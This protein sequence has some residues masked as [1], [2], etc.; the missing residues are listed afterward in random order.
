GTR[1]KPFFYNS[2]YTYAYGKIIGK[3]T[4]SASQRPSDGMV[5]RPR[6]STPTTRQRRHSSNNVRFPTWIHRARALSDVWT[7]PHAESAPRGSPAP[8]TC[9]RCRWPPSTHARLL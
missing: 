7:G 4:R 1:I 9:R 3:G 6:R 8:K 5:K 2:L